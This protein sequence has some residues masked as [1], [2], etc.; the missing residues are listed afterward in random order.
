M[1]GE[2]RGADPGIAARHCR[3]AGLQHEVIRREV[4]Q[5]EQ[6]DLEVGREVGVDIAL[7]DR[8]VARRVLYEPHLPGH[9][10]R[11]FADEGES[12]IVRAGRVRVHALEIEPVA[13]SPAEVEQD[14]A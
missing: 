1:G 9:R 10:E 5:P 2:D 7:D 13:L 8:A 3:P 12:L 4:V 6:L 14:V 11:I